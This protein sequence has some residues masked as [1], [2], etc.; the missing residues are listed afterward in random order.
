[1]LA[2]VRDEL[3]EQE[4]E[5]HGTGEVD[6]EALA[7]AVVAGPR[8]SCER[9]STPDDRWLYSQREKPADLPVVQPT[10]F[11]LAHDPGT[12]K[13]LG[14]TSPPSVLAW[15]DEVIQQRG[16]THGHERS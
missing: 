16:D 8:D 14:S 15:A 12:A 6:S 2:G 13:A 9:R 5:G 3:V 7:V 11:E 4:T 10:K 1:M